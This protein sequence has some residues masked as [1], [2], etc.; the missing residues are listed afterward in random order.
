MARAVYD[1]EPSAPSA[2]PSREGVGA[3]RPSG[4]RG[5]DLHMPVEL[6]FQQAVSGVTADLPADRL[7]PCAEC[8]AGG[9]APGSA[10]V[11]CSHCGGL[12]TVWSEQ[13][14]PVRKAAPPAKDPARAPS[15]PVPPAAAVA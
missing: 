11:T 8:G 6:A 1:R 14:A 13:G 4:R 2:K 3:P 5:D 12:G 15:I 7:S 9:A 10:R